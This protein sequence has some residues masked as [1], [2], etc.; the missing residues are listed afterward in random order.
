MWL[1]HE[2]ANR[3]P[4][5]GD[6]SGEIA[7][8]IHPSGIFPCNFNKFVNIGSGPNRLVPLLQPTSGCSEE[9]RRK[10]LSCSVHSASRGGCLPDAVVWLQSQTGRKFPA[11]HRSRGRIFTF[12][13]NRL[14]A[15]PFMHSSPAQAF[16]S[17]HDSRNTA[18]VVSSGKSNFAREGSSKWRFEKKRGG[19]A[20]TPS[21]PVKSW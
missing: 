8:R 3:F 18:R 7:R 17:I 20:R 14:C 1:R 10:G 19:V 15:P 5:S 12:G 16:P 2:R 4:Q 6:S 11:S 21:A 13:C 9:R